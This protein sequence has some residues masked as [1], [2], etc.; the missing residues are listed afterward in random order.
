MQR[1]ADRLFSDDYRWHVWLLALTGAVLFLP[2]LGAVHLFD[3]DEINFAESAR[4]MLATG[5]W[6]TVRIN[7]E[8][9][10]EK[11]PLFFWLQGA[12]MWLFGVNEFA[13]RLP[14]ALFGILTL[15]TLFW[16]GRRHVSAAFGY[17]WALCYLGSFLPFLY[18]KSGI[19]DP[20]FNFFIFLGVYYLAW[21]ISAQ[22]ATARKRVV[23]AGVFTGLAMLTKGPVGLL[24]VG[25]TVLGWWGYK[26]RF[27][28]LGN[29]ARGFAW[30]NI[31]LYALAVFLVCML[32]YGIELYRN[33][34]AGFWAFIEY[35]IR[36]LR[37]P[38][39][40]HEQPFYYHF[41]VVLIGCFPMSA[42][43]LAALLKARSHRAHA[44][45]ADTTKT[46]L[47]PWMVILL[48]VVLVLFSLVRT[49]IVHYSSM[50]YLPLSFLAVSYLY[51]R[52]ESQAALPAWVKGLVFGLGG[53][54]GLLLAGFPLLMVHRQAI[55][56]MIKDPFAVAGLEL[57]VGWTYADALFGLLYLV[58]LGFAGYYL[59]RK[60]FK[61]GVL[62]LFHASALVLLAFLAVIVP[63]VEQ[64]TQAPAIEFFQAHAD[65]DAYKVT[66]GYRSYAQ[67]FYGKATPHEPQA[68]EEQWLLSGPI[69]RPVYFSVKVTKQE[70]VE[71]YA[72]IE[73]LYTKGGFAFYVRQPE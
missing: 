24:L 4:E 25:L 6:A 29:W 26:R 49:K 3:W 57:P 10:I 27:G 47:W 32:W 62:L 61:R 35:Q 16:I 39:A 15:L 2:F 52:F 51:R 60:H 71:P 54:F 59:I 64:H 14:N 13:A 22:G 11:P 66:V 30:G 44:N 19:I 68:P 23:W 12:C 20:V 8:P 70:I 48:W 38:D 7:F 42:F 33:G 69:D 21:A 58:V 31:G 73:H 34:W 63:K 37:T 1:L 50:A 65:E 56:P 41:V 45:E 55:Y 28:Q 5:D 40:G 53:L 67:H 36:L 17:L 46:H 43:G 9:F 18:F 72:D